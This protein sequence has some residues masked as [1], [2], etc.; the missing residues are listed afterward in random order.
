MNP[1]A[2]ID[3][4]KQEIID[5]GRKSVH[6]RYVTT[7]GGNISARLNDG[8]FLITATGIPLDELN[9]ENIIIVNKEGNSQERMKPSKETTMH[10]LI[11]HER[12][13]VKSV[14]HLHPIISTTLAS[15]D[16]PIRPVTFEEL[17]FIGERI[18]IVSQM[19]AGGGELHQAVLDEAKECNV[20]ILKNHG[21]VAVG[22]T[23]K[24]AYFRIVKLERA[25]QATMIARIF[26]KRIAPFPLLG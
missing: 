26:D 8:Q 21:C 25:A 7:I 23:L 20:V 1:Q 17:Y 24:E 15:I 12:P 14:V 5:I 16:E 4:I 6:Y 2:T 11:Y 22:D 19:A 3:T 10:L 13:D 9:K 18:G